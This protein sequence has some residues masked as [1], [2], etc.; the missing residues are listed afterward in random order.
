[1]CI[2]GGDVTLRMRAVLRVAV[3]RDHLRRRHQVKVKRIG[4]IVAALLLAGVFAMVSAQP[5]SAYSSETKTPQTWWTHNG[6]SSPF[7]DAPSGV[8]FTYACNHHDGCYNQHW[9]DKAT[10]DIWFRNDMQAACSGPWTLQIRNSCFWWANAYY[11]GVR[12]LGGIFYTLRWD[13][14]INIYLA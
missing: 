4:T 5:A 1:M 7:G 3:Y 9:A 6:C 11:L 12:A 2:P 14:T 10:C 13:P 8:S